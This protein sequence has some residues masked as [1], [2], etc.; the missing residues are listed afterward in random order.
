MTTVLHHFHKRKRISKKLEPYPHPNKWVRFLDKLIYII[1]IF[2]PLMTIPQVT[3]IWIERNPIGI[4]AV[5]WISY[6]IMAIIWFIYGIVHKEKPLV[7]M[8][9]IWFILDLLIVIG[10]LLYG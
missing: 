10:V 7:V 1:G 9:S 8:Y 6:T 5:S 3:K 2:G 4:S